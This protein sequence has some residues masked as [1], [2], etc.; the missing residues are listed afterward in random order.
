VKMGVRIRNNVRVTNVDA[1]GVNFESSKTT[2]RLETRTVLWAGGVAATEFGLTVAQRLGVETDKLGR[3]PVNPD[4]TVANYP[5]IY[6]IGDQ[7][8]VR[9][10]D[11]SQLAGVAQV[12]MQEGAYVAHAIACRVEGAKKVPPFRYQDRGDMA[13]IGRAAAVGNLFGRI[14]VWGWPAWLVWLFIH[15]MYLVQFS[16]RLQVFLQWGIQYVTFSRGARLI[17]GASAMDL[18]HCIETATGE[19][20]TP[21]RS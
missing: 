14:H 9:R 11:G 10:E 3:I 2:E 4:L 19:L 13:V 1:K 8:L 20:S 18:E 17:T 6:V 15:L 16:S 12:A 7:A 5:D 21:G